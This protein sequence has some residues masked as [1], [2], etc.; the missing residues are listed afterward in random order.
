MTV[1]L[2]VDALVVLV[3]SV[4]MELE[5]AVV[6]WIHQLWDFSTTMPGPVSNLDG[7]SRDSSRSCH[8]TGAL[9]GELAGLGRAR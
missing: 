7:A 2:V 3:L 6:V 4:V 9:G 8:V 1:A 5:L